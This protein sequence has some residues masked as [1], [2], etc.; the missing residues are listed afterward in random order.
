[1]KLS[2]AW[3]DIVGSGSDHVVKEAAYIREEALYVLPPP[4]EN[5]Q[6]ETLKHL[7]MIFSLSLPLLH[8]LSLSLSLPISIYLSIYFA[9]T[10][11]LCLGVFLFIHHMLQAGGLL[12][13]Q[14]PVLT[15]H[16]SHPQSLSHPF[17]HLLLSSPLSPTNLLPR[18]LTPPPRP[19]PKPQENE[20]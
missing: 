11:C 13:L 20:V 1:M 9:L 6:K 12:P 5:K 14:T 8:H 16:L 2:R 7:P 18:F 4:W 15:L 3:P 19:N 17:P 10:F